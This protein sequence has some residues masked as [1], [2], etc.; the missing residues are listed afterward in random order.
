MTT[1]RPWL[2]TSLP[3]AD[4]VEL[5]LAEMTVAEKA[6][7]F[8]QTMIAL[9]PDGEL[10]DGDAAFGLPSTAEYVN[11]R[12]MTHFNLLGAA[13]TAGTI[14][15]WHNRLQE[16]AA[17][18]RLGIPVTISMKESMALSGWSFSRWLRPLK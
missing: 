11:E 3:V 9:G 17:S 14:A 5:L 6:G 12:H 7:L 13:P 1:E 16:L 18:T 10:S 2:D 8:F 4:R 15:R